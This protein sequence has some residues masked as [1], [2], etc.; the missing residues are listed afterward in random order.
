MLA[1]KRWWFA[2]PVSLAAACGADESGPQSGDVSLPA[3]AKAPP[4]EEVV[5]HAGLRA[6]YVAAVQKD[7]SPAYHLSRGAKGTISARNP[8]QGLSAELSPAGVRV[9]ADARADR[10]FELSLEAVGCDGDL[11]PA[12]A[13]SPEASGNR[14]EYRRGDVVEWYL[15][16]PLGLE[17]GFDLA[18]RPAC[19]EQGGG[20][21]TLSMR[22]E[23]LAPELTAEADAALLRDEAGEVILRYTDLHVTDAKGRVL[24]AF[25]SA[26]EGRIAIHVDDTGAIYPIVV[27]PIVWS[28]SQKLLA[29]D[30]QADASLGYAVAIDA[31]TAVI[32]A[33]DDDAKGTDSGAAYVFL[34]NAATNTWTQSQK[35]VSGDATLT[36]GDRFGRAVTVA[37]NVIAV[38][39]PLDNASRGVVFVFQRS[40]FG[41]N[42]TQLQKITANDAAS[43]DRFG[44]SVALS[45]TTLVVGSPFDDNT[46]GGVNAVDTGSAY[47]YLKGA[48]TFVLQGSKLTAGAAA[49]AQD[50]FGTAV[51]ISGDTIVVG[52]YGDDDNGSVS[53]SAFVFFRTGTTWSQQAKLAPPDGKANDWFGYAVAVSGDTA[54]I[55]APLALASQGKVYAY[56]RNAGVWAQQAQFVA[57]DGDG[58]DQFGHSVSLVVDT[59]VIGARYDEPSS[60]GSA[61][62]FLRNAGVWAQEKKITGADLAIGDQF[63]HSVGVSGSWVIVGAE[64]HDSAAS[65]AGAAY[66]FTPQNKLDNGQA[67]QV[68]K[69]CAS[70]FC[71]DGVC[72]NT[73]CGGA[74]SDCQACDLA[75]AVGTCTPSAAGTQCRASG[76]ACDV[77]EACDGT[78]TA[79]P[80]DTKVAAGTQCRASAGGCDPAEACDG[81]S[82]T[83]PA[84][85]VAAANT[86]CRAA[87]GACDVD[88]ICDG[89]TPLCPGDN[90]V[91]AGTQC[92]APAGACDAAESCDGA[93]GVCPADTKV[94][95]G[96]ECRG[97][98]GACD[99]AEACDGAS[100]DCPADVLASTGTVCRMAIG[101]CDVAESC[102]GSTMECPADALA[103][104]GTVCR[105]KAG[106]CDVAESCDGATNDCPEDGAAPDGT[107]CPEGTCQAGACE[108]EGGMG[109]GGGGGA[110]GAG[111]DGGRGGAGGSA[112][113]GGSLPTADEGGCD[114]RAAGTSRG[115]AGSASVLGLALGLAA[116][117]RRLRSRR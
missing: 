117:V 41:S 16:G 5:D 108:G 39:A 67:C 71:A 33:P 54:L 116:F 35:L 34:R 3:Q 11:E 93:S 94:A 27:D 40:A 21:V 29:G 9:A 4:A 81:A 100:N 45:G 44:S 112:G 104:A 78:S 68:G 57:M 115:N 12:A 70:G 107:S 84:D 97:M 66:L 101:A 59:A 58:G 55:A 103:A 43:G 10:P 74:A 64:A 31:D 47:V 79:C 30:A 14:A 109:G 1:A 102:D 76:G 88:E 15:N 113:A 23:G 6:A 32:G 60:A 85:M 46:V 26:G 87:V 86:V 8:A 92:R 90:L 56:T 77:A 106:D 28:E 22:A 105:D 95:A 82:N 19:R 89:F 53:G 7:A 49:A 72:C 98:A 18:K 37:G 91:P 75:G 73:A 99:A 13:A 83:C 114:C 69:D 50:E 63:G 25:L 2:L 62:V 110:G 38:G 65:N 48:S 42:F 61:Y 36:A 51:A 20:S 80:A 24:P 17:Q 111:G 96:T 52:A